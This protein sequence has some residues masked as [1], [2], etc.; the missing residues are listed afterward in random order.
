MIPYYYFKTFFVRQRNIKLWFIFFFISSISFLYGQENRMEELTRNFAC[1]SSPIEIYPSNSDFSSNMDIGKVLIS[2]RTGDDNYFTPYQTEDGQLRV[3]AV[4]PVSYS[5]S[6]IHFTVID[7]DDKSSYEN[8]PAGD[9]NF[10]GL[11]MLSAATATAQSMTFGANQMAVAEVTLTITNRYSGDNYQIKASLDAGFSFENT[12]TSIPYI[13]WKR[14]YFEYHDMYK[15]GSFLYTDFIPD[16]NTNPDVIRIYDIS[17]L[18][19][20][21]DIE[22]FDLNHSATSKILSIDEQSSHYRLTIEDVNQSFSEFSGLKKVGDNQKYQITLDDAIISG[23][24]GKMGDG[25]D[26]GVFVDWELFSLS[27][28]NLP[29]FHFKSSSS[30]THYYYGF[31]NFWFENIND[32]GNIFMVVA[33]GMRQSNDEGIN[34]GLTESDLNLTTVFVEAIQSDPDLLDF[35]SATNETLVHEIGHQLQAIDP[36]H[37]DAANFA[38]ALP[39]HSN[40]EYCIMTYANNYNNRI[41]EFDK[42]E[43]IYDIRK[44]PDKQ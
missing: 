35:S 13:A 8:S 33:G 25:S 29:N 32:K 7:P 30:E 4:L 44:A 1:S 10:G 15:N 24:Y 12:S 23:A 16:G 2:T 40:D 3:K 31:L 41:A 21:D 34:T 20:N 36:G 6:T 43:C 42:I 18:A 37:V 19:V 17:N 26:G 11:G 38:N 27:I 28:S 22:I 9:D 5:G 39:A 14:M